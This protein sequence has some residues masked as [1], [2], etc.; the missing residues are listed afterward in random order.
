MSSIIRFFVAPDD[1]VAAGVA[2]GGPGADLR[3]A[4]YGNFD[5]WLTLEEWESI[6]L[7]RDLDEVGDAGG[8]DILSGAD[9]P[10]VL[11]VPPELTKALAEADD[12]TLERAVGRWIALRAEEGEDIEDEL[13]HELLGEVAALS[14]DAERTRGGL[15]CWIC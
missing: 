15:Y 4:T 9:G 2:E 10:V 1:A 14:A 3:Q 8:P 7:N 13:A 12:D 5:V 11:L 6:L